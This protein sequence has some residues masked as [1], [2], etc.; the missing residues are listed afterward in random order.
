MQETTVQLMLTAELWETLTN[1]FVIRDTKAM[2]S[3]V[4]VS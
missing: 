2:E 1:A 3:I 4:S